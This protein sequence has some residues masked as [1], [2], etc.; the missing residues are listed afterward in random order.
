MLKILMEKADKMLVQIDTFSW[1]METLWKKNARIEIFQ[2]LWSWLTSLRLSWKRSFPWLINHVWTGF[3]TDSTPLCPREIFA[4]IHLWTFILTFRRLLPE[5]ATQYSSFPPLLA[6]SALASG[7][8]HRSLKISAIW[9]FQVFTL[10]IS[11]S[12]D[13]ITGLLPWLH[14][15]LLFKC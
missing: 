11:T 8:A 12:S 10:A 14:S 7:N 2:H 5:R 9:G 6:C 13:V 3:G 15:K 1:E 4:Q